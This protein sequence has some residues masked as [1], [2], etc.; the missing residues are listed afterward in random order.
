M[1]EHHTIDISD[2]ANP[3]EMLSGCPVHAR[4]PMQSLDQLAREL[5]WS[6]LHAKDETGRMGL[7][8]F[9]ALGG[10]Y[11]VLMLLIEKLR[12]EYGREPNLED[13]RQAK[14]SPA[15]QAMT[16]CCASAGNHG[17]SVAAGANVFGIA[18]EVYLADT[19]PESF[20]E[21]LRTKNATVVRA[22]KIYEDAMATARHRAEDNGVTLVSDA[23]WEGEM[24]IPSLVMQ[25]Y[26]V[27]SEEIR[28][29]FID[30]DHW[31]THVALQAGVGG[32]AASVAAHI[33]RTWPH[34]PEIIIVEPDRAA[35]L[36]KSSE[37]GKPVRA[38]G[39]VSNMGR[40]DC[41]EVSLRAFDELQRAADHFVTVTD[42]EAQTAVDILQRHGLNTTPSGAAGLAGLM[43]ADLPSSARVLILVTEGDMA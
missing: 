22:G 10:T 1:P 21:R 32:I 24:R 15:L 3:L 20:A 43:A 4:T 33:R 42:E 39:A 34:Q 35:C 8:S 41:K 26:A 38:D 36:K 25:G 27:M 7:G 2:P 17:L 6:G 18:C 29:Y 19:V 16:V 37:A 28:E 9:K 31:P 12:A 5:G 40:L 13:I 14:G 23:S 11:A 30:R